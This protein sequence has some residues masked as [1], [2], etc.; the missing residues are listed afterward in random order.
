MHFKDATLFT[1]LFN[2][3]ISIMNHHFLYD[4]TILDDKS[5]MLCKAGIFIN[6]TNLIRVFL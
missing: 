5:S 4:F 3:L 6:S 1:R 2:H